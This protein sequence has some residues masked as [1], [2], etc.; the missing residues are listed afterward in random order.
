MCEI[1]Y[2]FHEMMFQFPYKKINKAEKIILYGLGNVGM[3]YWRQIQDSDYCNVVFAVDKNWEEKH[4]A[5]LQVK[6]P[7][8]I[9]QTDYRVVVSVAQEDACAEILEE[10]SANSHNPY[11]QDLS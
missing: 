7:S 10:L 8:A 11:L 1:M 2:A 3:S 6:A 5:G 9:L 4:I